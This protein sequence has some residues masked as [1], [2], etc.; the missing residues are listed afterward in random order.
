MVVGAE[1]LACG[2]GQLH[3][4]ATEIREI[5]FHQL[6]H[7]Q[8]Q[9]QAHHIQIEPPL[10]APL[11]DQLE[12]FGVGGPLLN[13]GDS[14]AGIDLLGRVEALKQLLLRGLGH[15]R[16]DRQEGRFHQQPI[17]FA[18]AHLAQ[19][20]TA[21]WR[22]SRSVDAHRSKAGRVEHGAVVGAVDQHHRIGREQGI[23]IVAA[24]LAA[25]AEIRDVVAVADDPFPRLHRLR[26]HVLA[27]H[28]QDVGDAAHRSGRHP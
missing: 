26:G 12:V 7:L 6:R 13:G 18:A 2:V 16:E 14:L 27:Q 25:I 10:L 20:Q 23:Q 9:R 1:R 28:P 3:R 8:N 17:G 21:S 24:E 4:P 19:D 15:G 5:L 11:A 22:W